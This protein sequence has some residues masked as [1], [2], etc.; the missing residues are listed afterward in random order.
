MPLDRLQKAKK[1]AFLLLKFR[2]RGEKEIEQRLKEKGFEDTAIKQAVSF[3]KDKGFINDKAFTKAW[4]RYRLK[5]PYGIKKIKE[6]LR[7]KGIDKQLLDSCI[8]EAK[9]KNYSEENIVKEIVEKKLKKLKGIEPGKA[10]RR[11]YAYL[12]ARGFSYEVIINA[13]NKLM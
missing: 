1:Y 2:L 11:L 3:L 7:L 10:K 13:I 6:E 4:I 9:D 5:K 12:F 8:S